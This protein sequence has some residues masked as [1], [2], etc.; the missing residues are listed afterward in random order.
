MPNFLGMRTREEREADWEIE[1]R[2]RT[3][4]SLASMDF[5]R[6]E[7]NVRGETLSLTGSLSG[8]GQIREA[9]KIA[10]AVSGVKEVK[11]EIKI[12]QGA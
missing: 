10:R 11:N 12:D 5:Q 3:A 4:W 6:I 9:E 2:I 1:K 7:A 8:F